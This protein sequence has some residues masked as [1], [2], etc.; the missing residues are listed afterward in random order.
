MD[1]RKSIKTI[2]VGTAS[3]VLLDACKLPDKKAAE[4]PKKDAAT[5]VG[6]LYRQPEEKGRDEKLMS[7]KFFTEQEMATIAILADIIIPADEVSG[8]ATDAKVP[9]FIEFIVKDM[10]QHQV[11]MRGGLRWLDIESMKRFEKNFTDLSEKQRLEIVDDIAYPVVIDRADAEKGIP[12]KKKLKPGMDQ[13]A[14]FFSLIRNLTATGFYTSPEG[15]K[16][17]GY[18]GNRPNK[19]NGVPEDV[20]K[21]YGLAYTEKDLKECISF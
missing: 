15:L 10:P 12:P 1:R 21:Q 5:N 4:E 6:N 18:V 2:A 19:W 20:L 7:D 16:D 9:D 14:A 8:S 17:L 13:G 3:G 11:P